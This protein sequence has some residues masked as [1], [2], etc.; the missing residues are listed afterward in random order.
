[1]RGNFFLQAE[2]QNLYNKSETPVKCR[3]YEFGTVLEAYRVKT[4]E[5]IKINL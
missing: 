5:F 3:V 1:M 4:K 2:E